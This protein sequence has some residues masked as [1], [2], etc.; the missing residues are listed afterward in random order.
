MSKVHIVCE[1]LADGTPGTPLASF[2][3]QH[4]AMS[5][6]V[7]LIKET[8]RK[9]NV[10]TMPLEPYSDGAVRLDDIMRTGGIDPGF[11]FGALAEL[12]KGGGY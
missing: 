1:M 7:K 8:D 6:A 4:D 2:A 9:F 5:H 3:A 10:Y 11:D 12:R